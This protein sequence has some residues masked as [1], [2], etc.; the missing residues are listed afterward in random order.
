MNVLF[1]LASGLVAVWHA[2]TT[3]YLGPWCVLRV[4]TNE[5]KNANNEVCERF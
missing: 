5:H 3:G 1:P 4:A 2:V